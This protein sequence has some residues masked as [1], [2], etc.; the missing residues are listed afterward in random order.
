MSL[1]NSVKYKTLDWRFCT[2]MDTEFW[3]VIADSR[4]GRSGKPRDAHTCFISAFL[5]GTISTFTAS[6]TLHIV[7][8]WKIH[9]SYCQNLMTV[10]RN[11]SKRFRWPAEL[12][13]LIAP[14][15]NG[16]RGWTVSPSLDVL[17][18][19]STSRNIV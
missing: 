10:H 7:F 2:D 6:R 3:H 15:N 9:D 1:N 8:A 14:F 5:W 4:R 16:G 11:D 17:H 18:S 13:R 12:Q 19:Q